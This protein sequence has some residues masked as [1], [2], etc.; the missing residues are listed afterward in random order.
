MKKYIMNQGDSDPADV[1]TAF[2]GIQPDP[3]VQSQDVEVPDAAHC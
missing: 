1:L 3:V 2:D